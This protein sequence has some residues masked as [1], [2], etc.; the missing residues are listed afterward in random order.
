MDNLNDNKD[1]F[2]GNTVDNFEDK[3]LT[4]N[5]VLNETENYEDEG[6]FGGG[7]NTYVKKSDKYDDVK[8][9]SFTMLIVGTLGILFVVLS[10]T[11]VIPIFFQATT[12]WLFYGIMSLVFVAFII[13]GLYSYVR[14]TKLKEEAEIEDKKIDEINTWAKENL[15]QQ[16]IDSGLDLSESIEILYFSRAE[17]IKSKLMHQFEDVDEGLIDLLA[18]SIYTD[19]YEN[20]KDEEATE[21][22]SE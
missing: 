18:E 9:S 11:N 16:N 10:L 1:I 22:L 17:R 21:E 12:S 20:N 15:N 5:E 7:D 13:G 8:S 4:D 6:F 19:I 3:P 2:E 14:A